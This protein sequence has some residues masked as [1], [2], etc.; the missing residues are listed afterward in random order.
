MAWCVAWGFAV[1]ALVM[2]PLYNIHYLIVVKSYRKDN[3]SQTTEAIPPV[4]YTARNAQ[5]F[6]ITRNNPL[7]LYG[8]P[9]PSYGQQRALPGNINS[10]LPAEIY[11]IEN[12]NELINPLRPGDLPPYNN[13]RKQ[14]L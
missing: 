1:F 6:I 2:L 14:P 8:Q 7:D 12:G 3:I 9:P 4:Q 5:V 11:N 10:Q 13:N